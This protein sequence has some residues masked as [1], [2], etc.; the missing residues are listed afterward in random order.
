[1]RSPRVVETVVVDCHV[2]HV[3]LG[4]VDETVARY[5]QDLGRDTP[6][7]HGWI[8]WIRVLSG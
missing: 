2:M 5:L 6:V 4:R 7:V 1:M 8:P 3:V